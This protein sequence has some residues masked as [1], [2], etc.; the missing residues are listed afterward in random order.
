MRLG[1]VLY[2]LNLKLYTVVAVMLCCISI[3]LDKKRVK[4][5]C[6]CAFFKLHGI[7]S[8]RFLNH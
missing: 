7:D 2:L 5:K 6:I 8:S 1:D 3:C 4:K